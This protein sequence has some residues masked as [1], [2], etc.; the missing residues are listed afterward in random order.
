MIPKRVRLQ[1][2][3]ILEASRTHSLCVT[4]TTN[5]KTGAKVYILCA[6]T[7]ENLYPLAQLGAM[8]ELHTPQHSGSK[9]I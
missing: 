5:R 6:H 2:Q 9:L 1:F 4:E 7:N 8:S 3:T